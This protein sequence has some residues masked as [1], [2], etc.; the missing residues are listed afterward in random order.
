M[1]TAADL[2]RLDLIAEMEDTEQVK[3]LGGENEIITIS[4]DK[5]PVDNKTIIPHAPT[6]LYSLPVEITIDTDVSSEIDVTTQRKENQLEKNPCAKNE[7]LSDQ[8]ELQVIKMQIY[9]LEIKLPK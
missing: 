6:E 5:N 9:L 4:H 8:N 3:T 1:E 7:L 2:P